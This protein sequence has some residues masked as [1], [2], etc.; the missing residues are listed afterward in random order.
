MAWVAVA[1]QGA[2]APR[3][4]CPNVDLPARRRSSRP[5]PPSTTSPQA[6]LSTT[7]TSPH[8]SSSIRAQQRQAHSLRRR[9]MATPS[10][11]TTTPSPRP[12]FLQAAVV[13]PPSPISAKDTLSD[14]H[15]DRQR[16]IQKFLASAELAQVRLTPF[17]STLFYHRGG[18]FS[19]LR[20]P[21]GVSRLSTRLCRRGTA[22]SHRRFS[23]PGLRLCFSTRMCDRRADLPLFPLLAPHAPI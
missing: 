6:T 4:L 22:R 14:D 19:L 13:V 16:A 1:S 23:S 2:F 3:F 21:V 12:R 20:A 5:P 7:N 8:R 9:T 11:S 17:F 10:S 18:T 15:D